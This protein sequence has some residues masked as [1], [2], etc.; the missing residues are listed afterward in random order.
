MRTVTLAALGV[1]NPQRLFQGVEVKGI[2]DGLD[3]FPLQG[4]GHRVQAHFL[5][6]GHLLDAD[7]D[8]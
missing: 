5:G 8:V 1:F 3:A 2:D 4:M 7:D 6:V